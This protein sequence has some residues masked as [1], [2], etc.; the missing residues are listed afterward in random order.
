MFKHIKPM[1]CFKFDQK[2]SQYNTPGKYFEVQ[3]SFSEPCWRKLVLLAGA[4]A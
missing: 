3:V 2:Y 4:E 1:G